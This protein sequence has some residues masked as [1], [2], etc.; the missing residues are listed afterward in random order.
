MACEHVETALAYQRLPR[1]VPTGARVYKDDCIFCFDTPENNDNG[2]DVCLDCYQAFS[3]GEIN[4][5][6]EHNRGKRHPFYLN[7][8]KTLKPTAE[9]SPQLT[10]EG[11]HLK[12]AKLEVKE[13]T[14]AD[15]YNISRGLYCAECDTLYEL[16]TLPA[17]FAS[18]VESIWTAN[19]SQREDD[20]KTWE[21]QVF[22]CEH[23]VDLQQAERDTVD[24]SKCHDCELKENLWICLH[25]GQIGC[26]REQFGLSL[27]GNSHALQHY[28]LCEHPVAVK[29]GSLSEDESDCDCYCYKCNDEVKVPQLAQK[30]H[31]YGIDLNSHVKTEKN[32]IELNLDQNLN[33]DFRLDGKN[34]EK[35]T[36]IFGK[37]LTG[38]QNLGNSCYLNSVIQAL[39]SLDDYETYFRS[40]SFP[41][42]KDPSTDLMSQLIKVNDGLNSGRYSKPSHDKGDE[43][44]LGIKP[45]AFKT[46]IGANHEEF[47][48]QK[49]QDA[50][51][52][53]LYLLDNMDLALGLEL[54]SLLKFLMAN[55]VVCSNCKTGSVKNELIDT[56]AVPVEDELLYKDADGKKVYKETSLMASFEALCSTEVI[57]GFQ[58]SHCEQ[59]DVRAMKTMGFKTFPKHL[60][61]NAKRIKL[62]NWVPVKVDVPIAVPEE[63]ELGQFKSPNFHTDEKEATEQTFT[64]TSDEFIPNS[65]AM[66]MLLSMGFPE[67]R[68]VKGLYHTGNFS[69]EDA[70][71]WLFAHMDDVGID[72][73]FKPETLGSKTSK[74]PSLEAVENLVSM[75]FSAQLAKKALI[76]NNNDVNASVEWLFS[77]PNDDGVI[78]NTAE[79]VINVGQQR[80]LLTKKL[81]DCKSSSS[82]YRLQAVVC[83]K[84]SSPHT[85]HYVVFV[86]KI[87]E[88]V[89]R[90]VLFNDEKVVLCD[91]N[92]E[93]ITNNG[94][95]YVF[96]QV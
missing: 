7:I 96:E 62:E 87:V 42:V 8:V 18:L 44:Q 55:K 82:K 40:K 53:L 88:G 39:F 33:W 65:E 74:E 84:G 47:K 72:E 32:L 43:Y 38:F 57:E 59:N 23:S 5:T 11:R 67:V 37:K 75:G 49:Q 86:K 46:L 41:D 24:L 45:A 34:G 2:L 54:N 6:R 61:V 21:Q 30:L 22:P 89:R 10:E 31:K 79:P 4:H 56:V 25:C 29:L 3:R 91:D 90:W 1:V 17:D 83:H 48:T 19:S 95:I 51:E 20:I 27:K 68:A 28:E 93:D 77:N 76:L 60:V 94:Y 78:D 9:R 35:L 58:C 64:E 63:M 73:P 13:V 36:P 92:L 50:Y 52:F 66:G 69:A 15:L 12:I 81:L 71:N 85:G 14:D 26:G 80:E 16:N 70:M